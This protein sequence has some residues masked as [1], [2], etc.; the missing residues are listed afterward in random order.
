M[1]WV[2]FAILSALLF[3]VVN[4]VDKYVLDKFVK[5][6]LVPTSI[7]AFVNLLSGLF[8]YFYLQLP[9]IP[10]QSAFLAFLG[11]ALTLL[12]IL[13]YFHA[14]KIEDISRIIPLFFISP[15]F[16]AILSAIFLGEL[17]GPYIYLGV[18]LLVAGA[19]LISSDN[20]LNV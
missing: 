15:L 16:V 14:L 2:V 20:P 4:V 1:S 12:A 7:F 9:I 19:I 5:N 18:V 6:P 11:G 13:L 8:L 10:I 17:F 3:A